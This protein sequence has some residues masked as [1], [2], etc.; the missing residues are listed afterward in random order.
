LLTWIPLFL[1]VGAALAVGWLAREWALRLPA[2][3]ATL[4]HPLLPWV[5]RIALAVLFIASLLDLAQDTAAL[6]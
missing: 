3:R 1:P 5:A 6:T 2:G 4:K